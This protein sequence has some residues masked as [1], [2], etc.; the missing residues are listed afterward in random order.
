M[1]AEGISTLQLCKLLGES[2]GRVRGWMDEG[3][4]EPSYPSQGQGQKA[5]FTREDVHAVQL[6]RKLVDRGFNRM[7]ASEC[8]TYY[9]VAKAVDKVRYLCF[10]TRVEDGKWK[11]G[12]NFFMDPGPL[13]LE[14]EDSKSPSDYPFTMRCGSNRP[15]KFKDWEDIYVINIQKWSDE[16]EDALDA[17]E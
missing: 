17:L 4:V 11:I 2:R 5:I 14:I 9:K 7:V 16:V 1:K 15:K 12:P 6:F 3:Y 13:K 8:A 10:T